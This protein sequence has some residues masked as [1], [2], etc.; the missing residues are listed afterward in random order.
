LRRN[1]LVKDEYAHL[2]LVADP[3]TLGRMRPLLH[4]ETLHRMVREVAK[5]LTHS[6][7]EDIER[8]LS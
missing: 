2:V 8:A 1:C 3:H 6:P 7:L 5:T 4:K